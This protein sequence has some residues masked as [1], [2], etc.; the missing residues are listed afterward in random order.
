M[1]GEKKARV[2][3]LLNAFDETRAAEVAC[4]S[5]LTD[6]HHPDFFASL[7]ITPAALPT[8]LPAPGGT[9]PLP[10]RPFR[11]APFPG[12]ARNNPFP[13]APLRAVVLRLDRC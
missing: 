8:M 2:D 9:L 1:V 4:D 6:Y 7:G 13:S 11:Q 10:Q 12:E 5:G 3:L